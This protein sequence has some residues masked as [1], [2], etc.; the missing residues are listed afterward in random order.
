M[1]KSLYS[2]SERRI[3]DI[4]GCVPLIL[5]WIYH[6]FPEMCP[7]KFAIDTWPLAER[8]IGA[9]DV[10]DV[11]R[12]RTRIDRFP[13]T[14][15]DTPE[16]QARIPDWMRSQH[17]V[18]TWRS[19]MLLVCFNFVGMHH[20]DR[21]IWQYGGE[22]PVPRHLVDVT[23]F[24][25]S[26]ARGDDVWWP[27]VMFTVHAGGDPRGIR[28]YYDWYLGRRA[29]QP[30]VEHGSPDL[31]AEPVHARDELA[32]PDNASA[33]RRRGTREPPPRTAATARGGPGCCWL[34]RLRTWTRRGLRRSRSMTDRK[35]L[36]QAGGDDGGDPVY[37]DVGFQIL[38]PSGSPLGMISFSLVSTQ[39]FPS[40]YHAGTSS[41]PQ[42]FPEQQAGFIPQTQDQ[43]GLDVAYQIQTYPPDQL[44]SLVASFRTIRTMP[45]DYASS[46]GQHLPPTPTTTQAEHDTWVPTYLSPPVIGYPVF[47]PT[48]IGYEWA[49]PPSYDAPTSYHSHVST[50]QHIIAPVPTVTQ[51]VHDQDPSTAAEAAPAPPPSRFHRNVRPPACGTGGHLHGR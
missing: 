46:S 3:T 15:Y 48:R 6:R 2:A 27:K 22:Q 35:S 34:V 17:E 8:L 9:R 36:L 37:E 39:Q 44:A 16:I 23:R 11:L 20:I 26:T 49:T 13:W 42:I 14:P 5:S 7:P 50:P 21:V 43:A 32:M 51:P 40:P 1:F 45:S 28:Q 10:Q 12:W 47:D 41:E 24:M 18:H 31:P 25:S 4:V 38:V 19:A 30:T 33:P 29:G